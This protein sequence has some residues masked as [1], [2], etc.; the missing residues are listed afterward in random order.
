MSLNEPEEGGESAFLD[1]LS[2]RNNVQMVARDCPV[3]YLDP[4]LSYV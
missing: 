3:F 1:R 2:S 4:L